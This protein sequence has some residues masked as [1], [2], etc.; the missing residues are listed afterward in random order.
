MAV[1][2]HAVLL[3]ALAICDKVAAFLPRNTNLAQVA[4]VLSEHHLRIG[5]GACRVEMEKNL[6]NSQLK[7]LT[8]YFGPLAAN[9]PGR[10]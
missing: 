6:V 8:V 9:N 7:A 5:G 2:G 1:D 3:A 4:A 10:G